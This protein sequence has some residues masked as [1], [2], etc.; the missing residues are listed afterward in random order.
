MVVLIEALSVDAHEGEE[1][2]ID[3]FLG[4]E[5]ANLIWEDLAK[6]CSHFFR[7]FV[8]RKEHLRLQIKHVLLSLGVLRENIAL[9]FSLRQ[10]S[11]EKVFDQSVWMLLDS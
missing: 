1:F 9:Q 7:F 11:D 6:I 10:T 4:L 2:G 8:K 3:H 5:D